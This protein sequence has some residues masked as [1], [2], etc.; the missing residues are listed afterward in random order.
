MW[1]VGIA[2]DLSKATILIGG[3]HYC[4]IGMDRV[5]IPFSHYYVYIVAC[6]LVYLQKAIYLC[7]LML[8]VVM[9]A[10]LMLMTNKHYVFYESICL[11]EL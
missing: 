4:R 9:Y 2:G 11:C 5:C 6:T 10:Q 3:M 1:V 8:L 7:P